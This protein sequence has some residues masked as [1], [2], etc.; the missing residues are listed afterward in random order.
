MSLETSLELN[1]QLLTQHNALLERLIQAMAPAE[2]VSPAVEVSEVD[3]SGALS[4]MVTAEDTTAKDTEPPDYAELRKQAEQQVLRL[5]KG[6]YRDEA[7]AI[8]AKQGAKKLGD[9]ADPALA[10][11]L[12]LARDTADRVMPE[13]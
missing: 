2:R 6:G 12:K 10:D 8:L 11:V 5:V 3:V 4:A 9:V 1:N 13:V 7:V